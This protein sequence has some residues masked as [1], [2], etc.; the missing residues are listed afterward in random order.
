[1]AGAALAAMAVSEK[2]GSKAPSVGQKPISE[3]TSDNTNFSK[4]IWQLELRFRFA[5]DLPLT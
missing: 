4:Q 2:M 1:M 3:C 5:P